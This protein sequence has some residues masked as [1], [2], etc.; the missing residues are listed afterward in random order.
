[1]EKV[2]GAEEPV[3]FQKNGIGGVTGFRPCFEFKNVLTGT[4]SECLEF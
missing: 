1:M 2:E 4:V 3:E